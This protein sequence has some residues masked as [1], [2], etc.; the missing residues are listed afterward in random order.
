MT[1]QPVLRPL[2][3]LQSS[4]RPLSGRCGTVLGGEATILHRPR[5]L[6]GRLL[7]RGQCLMP[8]LSGPPAI[9]RRQLTLGAG[10]LPI[11]HPLLPAGQQRRIVGTQTAAGHLVTNHSSLI[12]SL[13][14]WSRA[15]A[16]WSRASAAWSRRDAHQSRL[17]ASSSSS[18]ARSSRS[19]AAWSRS[20]AASSLWSPTL[21]LGALPVLLPTSHR[22]QQPC[23]RG[24]VQGGQPSDNSEHARPA[25][26]QEGQAFPAAN[27]RIRP[28]TRSPPPS[29]ASCR[30][31][32]TGDQGTPGSACSWARTRARPR[33]AARTGRN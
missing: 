20:R 27:Q 13:A 2:G 33:T 16:A 21:S 17:T 11:D 1:S 10:D 15:S 30:D 31:P 8:V 9:G 24:I 32:S 19:A 5:P 23:P 18:S 7:P 6:Q 3:P 29:P 12:A 22:R 26:T 14:A 4:C 28:I 25:R